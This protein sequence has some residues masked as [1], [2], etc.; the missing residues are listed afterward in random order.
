MAA[1]AEA[2]VAA[3]LRGVNVGGHGR[4]PMADLRRVV[5][6]LG[7]ADVATL[8]QSGNVVLRPRAGLAPAA[9]EREL[10]EAIA[11]ELDVATAVLVRTHAEL[12]HAAVANPFA[13]DETDGTRL[14]LVLLDVEPAPE[15]VAGL[16]P[17]RSAGDRFHVD[18]RTVYL[19]L[20]KGSNGTKLTGAWL[21]RALG[22]RATA[23]NANTIEKLVALTAPVDG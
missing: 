17:G 16:D 10:E 14:H 19:H 22:V 9:I 20:P 15:A 1:Q 13:A 7:H 5:E 3:L 18:G 12:R 6:E 4:L 23:R 11:R 2:R 21:E 8:L